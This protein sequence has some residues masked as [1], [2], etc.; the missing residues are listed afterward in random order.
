MNKEE[1]I[2]LVEKNDRLYGNYTSTLPY[3][4]RRTKRIINADDKIIGLVEYLHSE[5]I[6]FMVM[7]SIL[8]PS[9]KSAMFADIY[10]PKYRIYVCCVSDSDK[11]RRSADIFYFH[12]QTTYYPVFSRHDEDFEFVLM[13]LKNTI[14]KAESNPIKSLY[15]P[16][17]T[18]K[19]KQR[20]KGIKQ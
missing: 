12:T 14:K 11:S 6:R 15:V 18:K 1:F 17:S 2:S 20:I 16:E 19:K 5:G 13:K 8:R 4:K 10:I 3:I 9:A 7:E